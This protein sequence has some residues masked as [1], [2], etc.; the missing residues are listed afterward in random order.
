M[1]LDKVYS[2]FAGKLISGELS[3]EEAVRV[4]KETIDPLKEEIARLK[5]TIK[6]LSKN[7]SEVENSSGGKTGKI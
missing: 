1:Q 2:D 4:I 5:E 6:K 7:L 3:K